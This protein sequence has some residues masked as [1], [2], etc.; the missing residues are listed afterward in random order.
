MTFAASSNTELLTRQQQIQQCLIEGNYNQAASFC[1]Q[2]IEAEPEVK[3]HYWNLGL[4][5]LLQGKEDEASTTWLLGMVEGDPNQVDQWTAELM[6]VLQAEAERREKLED[7]S[8]AWLMR[9]HIREIQP[10][11]INNLLHLIQLSIQQE[12]FSGEEL[13]EWGVIELL[14][15]E[16][17]I[18]LD[19]DLLLQVLRSVLKAAFLHP[20]S[21]ELVEAAL[22]YV[23]ESQRWMDILVP[24]AMEIAYSWRR[25]G[26][27]ARLGEFYRR[28][29]GDNVELLRHLAAF[30]QN[31]GEYQQGIETAKLCYS[32]L[33]ELPDKVFA[34]NLIL[35]GTITP[36]G[37]WEEA[38][39]LSQHQESLLVSLVE[40]Q[41]KSLSQL[42]VSRLFNSANFFAPYIKDE[43]HKIRTLR[44]QVLQL[45]HANVEIYAQERIERYR[46][47]HLQR[48]L[49]PLT[50]PLKIGYLSSCLREHSVGWLAR[51]VFQYHDRDRF[52]INTY[53]V[54]YQRNYDPLHEWY[55][56]K[57]DKIHY[58]INSWEIADQIHHDGID[59]LVDLD[60]LTVD[61]SCE[62][63]MLKSAPVQVT[64]L[65]WDASGVPTVD[66]FIA[67][68]YVL[69]ESAQNYYTEKI[70]RLPETY[71][72]ID[73]FE[74]GVPTI[75][76]DQL[77]IPS[78]AVVYYC[79]Q[80]GFKRH[81]DTARLQMQI[82]K[83]VPNS[84][85]LIKGIG[86]EDSLK[87]F[88]TQLAEEEGVDGDRL[89]FLPIVP[90][91]AVHR[92]NL[93]IADVVLDTYP[94][95]GATTTME[96][97]W[98]GIPMVT[99]VGEQ[100]AARNSYTMMINAGIKE[101][102]AWTNEEYIEW[103]I[104]LGKDQALRQ[105]ISWKLRASR[106]TAPLWNAEKFTYEMEQAYEQMWRNYLQGSSS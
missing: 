91:E 96:T 90:L 56:S 59:I 93:G 54:N 4:M 106:Q 46:Q 86:D 98:M 2:A 18:A 40:A 50:K 41:P 6:Q 74:V 13:K 27:A 20:S 9:G 45:G 44:N 31:A 22:S 26:I 53:F 11:D 28:I 100:F 73:G 17:P 78:D 57:S 79:G 10:S 35:R 84:Y 49:E 101:G 8:I 42:Q 52:Q 12:K 87:S 19:P 68:P 15:T 64:W 1:E 38:C 30:Y 60:S 65:G 97:L 37:Y 80:R 104:L 16:P 23:Q 7:Y 99:R 81:P 85:L 75:R 69:P 3:S 105:Q 34:N 58:S 67:D 62:V 76:R 29:D 39:A 55:I 48:Q 21:L 72:A 95:N 89:R 32:L 25:P 77:N 94:Y 36:G 47:R 61:I 66:Y 43:P 24:A 70:W 33:E 14:Q 63:M 88:F 5:L 103:G 82:L 51:W 71:L 102:I 92:A 83:E